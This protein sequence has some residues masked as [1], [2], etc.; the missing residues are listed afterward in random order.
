MITKGQARNLKRVY[1]RG[2]LLSIFEQE[3]LLTKIQIFDDGYFALETK[4]W[5][6]YWQPV[7]DLRSKKV[8]DS[9]DSLHIAW[10][11]YINSRFIDRRREYCYR[12]FVLLETL[13]VY[14]AQFTIPIWRQA[15]EITL[16]FECFAINSTFDADNTFAAGTCTLR[17]PCYLLA[18]L[19]MPEM[20]DNP[21]FLPIIMVVNTMKAELFYHYR[22][23]ILTLDSSISLFLYPAVEKE[24]RSASFKLI[25]LL[26]GGMNLGID[27]RTHERAQRICQGIIRPLLESN[28]AKRTDTITLELIDIGAGSGSVSGSICNEI[29]HMNFKMKFLLWLVDLEPKN[30]TRFFGNETRITLDNIV[31]LGA[32]YRDWL[33]RVNPL[34]VARGLRIAIVSKLLNNLSDFSIEKSSS[35]SLTRFNEDSRD[36]SNRFFHRPSICL[37][38]DGNGVQSLAISN[39]RVYTKK[40]RTFAQASL[41]EYYQGIFTLLHQS[42]YPEITESE[43][44]LPVRS[45]NTDCLVTKDVKSIIGCLSELCNYTII[46]DADLSP[47]NIIDHASKFSLNLLTIYDMTKVLKL[48]GNYIYVIWRKGIIDPFLKGERI[49]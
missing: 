5:D 42:E 24:K 26:V 38:P 27:P 20:L 8:Q 32:D 21:Q 3:K 16:G 30:V 39:S 7:F 13:L 11:E 47:Q 44:F 34:P 18:K 14:D 4:E 36:N 22:Q 41:S 37:S 43:V 19:K 17:N 33:S 35:E 12:Y 45:F 6:A 25:N 46:E 49:W 29:L 28:N 40:G 10:K 23:Y 1:N 31:F 48:K 9:I 15:L 2:L